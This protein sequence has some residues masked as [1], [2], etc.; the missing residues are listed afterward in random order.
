[1]QK[2]LFKY[3]IA[4]LT[5]TMFVTCSKVPRGIL[6]ENKM[7]EVMIDMQLAENIMSENY[8]S[9][10]DSAHRIAL[11][12]A[13]FRKHNITQAVYDS[14]LVWYGKNLNILIQVYDLALTDINKRIHDMGDI[15]ASALPSANQ[16][17]LNIWPR[18]NYL[19]FY[20]KGFNGTL[21]NIKPDAAY[22][23][24]SSFSLNLY[25]WG[26][27]EQM[28]HSPEVR[29][30]AEL[31][32]TTF[33]INQTIRT[34]GYHQILLKTLPTKPI[35]RIYGYI[36]MDNPGTEYYKIYIDS[37]SLIKYNYGSP[38]LA[39]QTDSIK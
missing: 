30:A 32:D 27:T 25:V 9:Y 36:R 33:I 37:L 17:S 2:K 24:G 28:L 8:Q 22:I 35:R 11:F 10:P 18:R 14:S 21:F 26:L 38:A 1:M 15:Q 39:H 29:I 16:D 13:V 7:K 4:L 19:T 6:P 3:S 31:V 34:D 5:L 20:P 12:R 23:S